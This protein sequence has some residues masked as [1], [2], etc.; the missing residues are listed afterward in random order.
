MV[1]VIPFY[2]LKL[3]VFNSI[4]NKVARF[5]LSLFL[6][7]IIYVVIFS[8]NTLFLEPSSV[9]RPHHFCPCLLVEAL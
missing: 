2:Y 1:Q 8:Q 6:Y 3:F 4:S 9:V 7:S 5:I